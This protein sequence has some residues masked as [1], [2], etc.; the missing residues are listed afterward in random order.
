MD[1]NVA[2]ETSRGQQHRR[3]LLLLLLCSRDN[4]SSTALAVVDVPRTHNGRA[5][6]ALFQRGRGGGDVKEAQVAATVAAGQ[7]ALGGVVYA[8]G[9]LVLLRGELN[10]LK[11]RRMDVNRVNSIKFL[12]FSINEHRRSINFMNEIVQ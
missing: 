10:D 7:V 4:L 12:V 5:V 6:G 11:R 1:H 3:L 8:A 9:R 2:V